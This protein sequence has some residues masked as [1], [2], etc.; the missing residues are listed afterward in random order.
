MSKQEV[1]DMF[2]RV[3]NDVRSEM[4]KNEQDQIQAKSRFH[5]E[6]LSKQRVRLSLKLIHL[7]NEKQSIHQ[8][9]A[10]KTYK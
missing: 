5:K 7:L 8:N 2:D 9:P 3:I 6:R 1:L 4:Q 10:Y